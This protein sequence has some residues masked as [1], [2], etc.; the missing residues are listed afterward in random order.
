MNKDYLV[1][2]RKWRPKSF[3]E[4]IGQDQVVIPLKRAIQLNRIMHAYLFSGPRGV[5]KTTTARVFA[6]AL[7]CEKGPTENPCNECSVCREIN[8][9][10]ALDVIEIDGASNRGIDEIR[11]LRE[12]VAFGTAKGRYKIYI[13]D[14]VHMLTK[15]AFN[16]LLKTLEEPPRHVIFIF[17]TTDPQQL[18][19][20]ILSRC[21]QFKFKRLSVNLI[22]DNLKLI[23]KNE[24]ID[25]DDGA[26]LVIARYADGALR[27]A[28][29]ILDQAITYSK[30]EK[31]T[32][33]LV[34]NL[35]GI[36]KGDILKNIVSAILKKEIKTLVENIEK[37]MEEGYDVKQFMRE[38]IE[39]FRSILFIKIGEKELSGII[40]ADD[41]D[42][43]KRIAESVDKSKVLFYLQKFLEI[44]QM[45]ARSHIAGITLEISLLD[46]I[47]KDHKESNIQNEIKKERDD[48]EKENIEIKK[49]EEIS[50]GSKDNKED[51]EEDEKKFIIEDI[52]EEIEVKELTKE[53]IIKRWNNIIERAIALKEEDD[54]IQT[55]EKIKI[56]TFENNTLFLLVENSFLYARLNKKIDI[57]LKI[58][59]DEFKKDIMINIIEKVNYLKKMN[60]QKDVLIEEI[61]NHPVVKKLEEIF[62]EFSEI[63]IKKSN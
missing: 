34:R 24:K 6:K 60:M 13:I 45:L 7:N 54:F 25:A 19:Q 28:Q 3:D 39:V 5:G 50:T 63:R 36:I 61:K 52:E 9:G 11:E 4:I 46:V 2:T 47:L 29:R 55:L 15:E 1:F 49:I 53:I 17:A 23:A 57:L 22:F 51:D 37:I 26:L 12:H 33:E 16:A 41:I 48:S 43:L 40:T 38:L 8:D 35:L 14:E 21:Q 32:D 10:S 44:E 62:G 30:G 20:T 31:I 42:F 56:I 18:P 27:D 59:K 58:L